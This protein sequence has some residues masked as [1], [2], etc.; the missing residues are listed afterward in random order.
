MFQSVIQP[1]IVS[2][3]SST[4]SDSLA[5]FS[6]NTDPALPSDSFICLLNDATSE[7]SPPPP[8]TLIKP[9]T[10]SAG[11]PDNDENNEGH[12]LAQTVLHIQS[13]TLP[14]TFIRCPPSGSS[15]SL[16]LKHP[17]IHI[18]V[19]NMGRE[20][21]FEV[22]V[23]DRAG[24][25]GV[26]RCSTFQRE[27]TLKHTKPPLLHLPFTFPPSSSHLLTGWSTIDLN[28]PSLLPHF[29]STSLLES[30]T[31]D[32]DDD[33]TNERPALPRVTSAQVPSGTYSHVS[34]VKV[35][36][37]CRLRRIWFSEAGPKQELPWEFQLFSS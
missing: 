19:R 18:Q 37:T 5:L 26:I 9:P 8:Q 30:S 31:K 6:S 1:G 27:P 11:G 16:G 22:G 28:L 15:T 2:L 4:G 33:E 7:P 3:F 24:R 36:A 10:L 35:Y 32:A 20:W 29:S 25:E 17:W 21:S 14:T 23:V 34:Y 12:T 13:P